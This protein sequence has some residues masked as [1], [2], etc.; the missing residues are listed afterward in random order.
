MPKNGLFLGKILLMKHFTLIIFI[1]CFGFFS[2]QSKIKVTE[3]VTGKPLAKASV[4]CENKFLGFTDIDG[5]LQFRSKCRS[6]KIKAQGFYTEDVLVE[7]VM[8]VKFAKLEDDM[9]EIEG[10]IINDKSDPKAILLLEKVN[11]NYEKNSP[12]S[13]PSYS[14]KSYEKISVDIDQDS[15]RQY[16][17]S[18]KEMMKFM[19]RFSLKKQ[20]SEGDSSIT[21]KEVFANSK[22]F[23]WERAQE[24]LYSKKYGEKINVLDNRIAGITQPMYE[25]M[26]VQSNRNQMPKEIRKEN[27]ELYRYFLTDTINIDG[28]Q[29]Y[30]I[31]FREVSYKKTIQ[32][33]K[34]NGYLYIDSETYGLKKIES[35]SKVSSEGTITS[36]WEFVDNK[37]FLQSENIKMK[38]ANMQMENEKQSEEKET[39]KNNKDEKKANNFR[40]YGFVN[41]IYFDHKSPIQE[42]AKDFKGYTYTIK[43]S[44]GSLLEKYR[45]EKLTPRELNTYIVIDSLGKRYDIDS[46]ANALS[47]IAR[48]KLR[49]HKIDL[50]LGRIVGYNQYEGFRLGAAVKMNERFSS[51]FSPDA[52][53]AYGFKDGNFKYGVGIDYNTTLQKTSTLRAEYY[54]DVMAAGRLNETFWDFRMKLNNAGIA[55]NND[56][57]YHFEGIKLSY[58]TDLANSLSMKI[59]TR[60][61]KENVQFQYEY[62]NSGSIFNNSSI[63]LSINYVPFSKNIMTPQGKFTTEKKYPEFFLNFEKSLKILNGN[64]DYSKADVLINHNFKWKLGTTGVRLYGGILLGEAP[65][66]HHFTM[67]G[68][69]G[70]ND[71][72]FNLTSYLGF[73]TMKGGLYYNDKFVGNY[74]THQIPWYFKS[75]GQNTSSFDIIHRSTIGN[76]NNPEFH[77]FEFQKL[78]HLYQ[79][80]G[81]EW[82][83]FLSSW[84]N[85][86]LFYRV[87]HYNT[88]KFSDNFA[89]Q[90]KFK[91]LG[92]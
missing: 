29:N 33:R 17:Q 22:L 32:K 74:I 63:I 24:F 8:L 16:N 13:L 58:E 56:R 60:K 5:E 61:Q 10:V 25:M 59:A 21:V 48:G 14:Y 92:F 38:L 64:F 86:G 18:L 77:N 75:F 35:N 66:W 57:F 42:N 1:F 43:N 47:S 65:I 84:F 7:D 80:V 68:L 26:S 83:N 55:L 52:Y 28:R 53:I 50:D 6:V 91:L 67:N 36:I 82:N 76:M 2:A 78:D 30:V 46:R 3:S 27:R 23:L 72:K 62:Q 39:K 87:G 9:Q 79:E 45:P 40:S 15:I 88:P 4:T 89:V 20:K 90:L 37:W 85:L 71:F 41:A 69:S 34:F 73:A 49:F 31:R 19:D 12:K 11:E 70:D 81:L 44:D 54:N 51:Y